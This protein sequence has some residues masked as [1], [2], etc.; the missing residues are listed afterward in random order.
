MG[1]TADAGCLTGAGGA[2]EAAAAALREEEARKGANM[3]TSR[4]SRNS[5]DVSA[6]QEMIRSIRERRMAEEEKIDA[7]RRELAEPI[8]RGYEFL[9]PGQ[10]RRIVQC[11]EGTS[12]EPLSMLQGLDREIRQLVRDNPEAEPS[13]FGEAT[14]EAVRTIVAQAIKSKELARQWVQLLGRATYVDSRGS[15]QLPSPRENNRGDIPCAPT[16]MTLRRDVP[17][18]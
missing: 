14:E 18:V 13:A 12:E 5:G 2:Q 8:E 17:E 4:L 9:S 7:H 16:A 15:M 3:E 6:R 10:I 11:L 1:A